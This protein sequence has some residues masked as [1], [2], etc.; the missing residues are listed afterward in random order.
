MRV[1]LCYTRTLRLVGLLFVEVDYRV[2]AC[3]FLKFENSTFSKNE[4]VTAGKQRY[5]KRQEM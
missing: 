3:C 4:L 2:V 5:R 1:D